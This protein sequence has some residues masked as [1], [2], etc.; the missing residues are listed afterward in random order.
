MTDIGAQGMTDENRR[1]VPDPTVLTTEQLHREVLALREL[2]ETKIAIGDANLASLATLD[3]ERFS[4]VERHFDHL[5]AVRSEDNRDARALVDLALS[6]QKE[7]TSTALV[8]ANLAIDKAEIAT[9]K[10]YDS[11]AA[12]VDGIRAS[13]ASMMPRLESEAR[14]NAHETALT[15]LSTRVTAIEANKSGGQET[16]T[17]L[18]AFAG[19]FV[20]LMIIAG[21]LVAL[22]IPH[23]G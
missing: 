23:K 5:D 11:L 21:M 2:L 3:A 22:G 17:A 16:K 13:V 7:L 4:R 19:F 9:G 1:P 15:A 14:H 10:R 20:T 18:Y 8:S 12:A 6:A